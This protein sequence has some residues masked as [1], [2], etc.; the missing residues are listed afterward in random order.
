MA[1][2]ITPGGGQGQGPVKIQ[3]TGLQGS[4][5]VTKA[6][7]AAENYAANDVLSEH[8][9]T[10]TVWLFENVLPNNGDRGYLVKAHIS[11]ETAVLVVSLTLFLFNASPTSAVN[12][13]V[14]NT[15][16]LHADLSQ[17]QGRIDFPALSNT[18]AGDAE[19]MAT[20]ST[21]GNLPMPVE[22]AS[23]ANDLIGILVTNDAFTNE[24]ATDDMTITLTSEL[25]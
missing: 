4:V 18:G 10:G 6:L 8:V 25:A 20:P 13:N 11:S 22:C 24:V 2:G 15:A 14:A 7:A 17:Y 19:A 21:S 9:S 5:S 3:G 16:L 23:D 12:D 1:E